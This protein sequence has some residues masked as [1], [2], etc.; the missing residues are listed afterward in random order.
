M[1]DKAAQWQER[2]AAWR[3]GDLSAAAFCRLHGLSYAQFGYWQR[4]LGAAGGALVP[5]R[6]EAPVR[7]ALSLEVR[8]PGGASLL[9]GGATTADVVALAR[10]LAC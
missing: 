9:V 8:L 7:V 4:R 2:F 1:T 5:V 10:G 6:I 3:A